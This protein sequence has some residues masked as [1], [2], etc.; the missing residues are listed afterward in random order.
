MAFWIVFFYGSWIF[1][2]VFILCEIGQRL[3][4]AIY[5]IVYEFEQLK[6]YLLPIKIQRILP[7]ILMNAQKPMTMGCFGIVVG[8]R[9]Q[10]KQV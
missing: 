3:T 7:I 2:F 9:N 5:A 6:W 1:G 4:D 8:D 10:F